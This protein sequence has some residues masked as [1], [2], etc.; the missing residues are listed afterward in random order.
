MKS[1]MENLSFKKAVILAGGKGT[2][3]YPITR[4]IPKPLLPVKGKPILY[5]AIENLKKHGITEIILSVGYKAEKIADYFGNGA[6]FGVNISY[7]EEKEP[8]GTGGAIKLASKNFQED[9]VVLNGDNVAD[10]DFYKMQEIHN[11]NEAK[12]TI[13]LY[14]VEDVTQFGIAKIEGEKI[15]KFIEKPKK[16]EAPS[17]LNNAGAYIINPKV[18]EILPDDF[19]LIEKDCFEKLTQKGVI[20]AYCHKG[21]WFPTD[22][23]KKYNLC[24]K[25]F[26]PN[27]INKCYERIFIG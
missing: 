19:F 24:R 25:L 3:L 10:F 27:P 13:A 17:N 21:Y 8:L 12:I 11:R 16:E 7:S 26:N 15:T 14:P 20:F 22:D 4:E 2:R 18:L 5:Y 1:K 23:I 6:N 9:F